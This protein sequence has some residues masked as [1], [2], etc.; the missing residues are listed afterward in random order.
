MQKGKNKK[1][2]KNITKIII[3]IILILMIVVLGYIAYNRFVIKPDKSSITSEIPEQN[4]LIEGN[5]F[6]LNG[7]I[8]RDKTDTTCTKEVKV[9]YDGANHLIKIK[10]VKKVT[11]SSV[12]LKNELYVDDKLLDTI[13]GGVIYDEK[14]KAKID[15]DG[16]IF[17]GEDKYLIIVT[18]FIVENQTNYVVNYY[19]GTT[20]LGRSVDI[21]N[22]EQTICKASCDDEDA[23]ILNNLEALEFDGKTLKF[24][25]PL[26]TNTDKEALQIGITIE[27]DTVI[28]KYLDTEDDVE[29]KGACS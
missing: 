17:I 12:T 3:S 2:E 22:G 21:I 16:Y 27:N 19:E 8:C 1:K 25:K 4:T 20:K 29:I 11:S 14:D 23:D 5:I 18:P 28:T 9:A 15:F 24:W 26:C 7:I 6:S 13:D 10:R